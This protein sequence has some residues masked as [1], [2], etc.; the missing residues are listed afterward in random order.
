MTASSTAH[1]WTILRSESRG[2][3]IHV[4]DQA[5]ALEPET[6]CKVFRLE[7]GLEFCRLNIR[8]NGEVLVASTTWTQVNAEMRSIIVNSPD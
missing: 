2:Q 3:T 4:T 7:S 8:P 5:D 1:G 6:V